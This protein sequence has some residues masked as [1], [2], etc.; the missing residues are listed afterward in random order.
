MMMGGKK[1]L[2]KKDRSGMTMSKKPMST[3]TFDVSGSICLGSASEKI[4]QKGMKKIDLK[5]C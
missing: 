3:E 2:G 5:E 1:G 4:Q